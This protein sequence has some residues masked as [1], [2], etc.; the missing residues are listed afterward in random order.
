MRSVKVVWSDKIGKSPAAIDRVSGVLYLHPVYYRRLSPF[1][2]NFVYWHEV[3]HYTL[4]TSDEIKADAYAFDV[5]AGTEFRSLKQSLTALS[6]VLSPDNPSLLPRYKALVLRA[7]RWDYR[8][9]NDKAG[10]LLRRIERGQL[11]DRFT[12][13]NTENTGDAITK[14][15][16][17]LTGVLQQTE[18]ERINENA[19]R[20]SQQ[21]FLVMVV[22]AFM[23][24][25]FVFKD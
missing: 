6:E 8:H 2:Q 11:L 10:E 13:I 5:L 21:N 19:A 23:V 12:L 16:Q 1:H 24:Y 20:K 7:L 15:M 4:D 25:Y 9:G 17:S 14:A 3:G 22:V 18:A